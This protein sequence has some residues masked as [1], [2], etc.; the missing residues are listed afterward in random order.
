MKA[1]TPKAE[2][3]FSRRCVPRDII[4]VVLVPG[5][6]PINCW[7]AGFARS[8]CF[9]EQSNQQTKQLNI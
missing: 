4:V 2:G 7:F 9:K 6:L 3:M 8:L 5:F 1:F